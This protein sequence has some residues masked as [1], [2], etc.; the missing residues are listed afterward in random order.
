MPWYASYKNSTKKLEQPKQWQ[1]LIAFA[2][3]FAKDIPY[4]RVDCYL[5]DDRIVFGE[6]T[7]Y[8]WAGWIDFTPEEWNGIL[9]ERCSLENLK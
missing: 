8:T 9:G 1:D 6:F 5:I 3:L 7:F 2:E 4:L